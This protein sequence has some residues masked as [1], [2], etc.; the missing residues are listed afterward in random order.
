VQI[1]T[2]WLPTEGAL[3]PASD[4]S[5]P[6][7]DIVAPPLRNRLLAGLTQDELDQLEPR[8]AEVNLVRKQALFRP[9]EP[10]EHVYFVEQG[11]VSLLAPW[12]TDPPVAPEPEP[13]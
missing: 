9:G 1:T 3:T 12:C 2:E 10:I 4:A 7:S 5:M 8:L 13:G 11:M 6:L